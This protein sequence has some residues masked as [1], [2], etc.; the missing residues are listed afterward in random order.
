MRST[1]TS[2]SA[3]E[4]SGPS[5]GRWAIPLVTSERCPAVGRATSSTAP[6][7]GTPARV[8]L[9]CCLTDFGGPADPNPRRR[10]F[11][12]AGPP[13]SVRQHGNGTRAGVPTDAAVLEVALATAGHRSLVTNGIAQRP[14]LGPE[15]SPADAD[16]SVDLVRP[17]RQ[18]PVHRATLEVRDSASPVEG[19]G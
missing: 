17:G 14:M 5:M 11:G 13:K 7:V 12:S 9:P 10:G 15:T 18:G 1:E 19:C 8:P 2:A 4:V 16:V 3:G 6:S